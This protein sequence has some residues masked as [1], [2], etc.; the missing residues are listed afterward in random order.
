MDT[1]L[2]APNMRKTQEYVVFI[3]L[4]HRFEGL[5]G[6]RN[7]R[8]AYF[9]SHGRETSYEKIFQTFSRR[10]AE[11]FYGGGLHAPAHL[12]SVAVLGER[13]VEW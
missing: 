6:S 12:L 3:R 9:V 1:A 7:M 4:A 2:I 5:R 8:V 11:N 10:A 13:T